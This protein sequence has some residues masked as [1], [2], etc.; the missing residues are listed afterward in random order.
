ML[1]SVPH[2]ALSLQLLFNSSVRSDQKGGG[3]GR[4]GRVVQK[5]VRATEVPHLDRAFRQTSSRLH[6]WSRIGRS[7][8]ANSL[9]TLEAQEIVSGSPVV[10]SHQGH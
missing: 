3:Q 5:R 10:T 1:L 8:L 6:V 9:H 2:L 4:A 7:S